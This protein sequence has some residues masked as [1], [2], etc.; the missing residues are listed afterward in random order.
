MGFGY[1]LL[2]RF[3]KY[4]ISALV[5]DISGLGCMARSRSRR[6]SPVVAVS[7]S[8]GVGGIWVWWVSPAAVVESLGWEKK[9]QG[10]QQ[11]PQKLYSKVF[12]LTILSLDKLI[13]YKSQMI[14][15]QWMICLL[16][17]CVYLYLFIL[18]TGKDHEIDSMFSASWKHCRRSSHWVS[19]RSRSGGILAKPKQQTQF[20]APG[21]VL[22][23]AGLD[24]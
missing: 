20:R 3:I 22:V 19:E 11:H 4:Q 8:V 9:G 17:T 16:P 12:Q 7:W 2:N 18:S 5:R 10:H 15:D 21:N 14:F 23:S 24:F 1:F 13:W 6:P